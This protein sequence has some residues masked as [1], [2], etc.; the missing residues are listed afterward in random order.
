[1]DQ[2]AI[3]KLFEGFTILLSMLQ[4]RKDEWEQVKGAEILRYS[5]PEK[6]VGMMKADASESTESIKKTN[7]VLALELLSRFN[8]EGIENVDN[9]GEEQIQEK[10][11][12]K[13][14]TDLHRLDVNPHLLAVRWLKEYATFWLVFFEGR[15]EFHKGEVWK[16]KGRWRRR[17]NKVDK[18]PGLHDQAE[19]PPPISP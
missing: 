8:Q 18:E 14:L 17:Q 1:M 13:F 3:L 16:G 2:L 6:I 19:L 9:N 11:W 15:W 5:I 12:R 4:N 7:A 10:R